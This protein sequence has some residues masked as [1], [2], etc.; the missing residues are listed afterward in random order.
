MNRARLGL[1]AV[2]LV[3]CTRDIYYLPGDYGF[4]DCPDYAE[5]VSGPPSPEEMEPLLQFGSRWEG[6]FSLAVDGST[7]LF[8][9]P[10][11]VLYDF[12]AAQ[13]A[14]RITPEDPACSGT[15]TAIGVPTTLT[16]LGWTSG[17]KIQHMFVAGEE[18]AGWNVGH[19]RRWEG[20]VWTGTGVSA[21]NEA[22]PAESDLYEALMAREAPAELEDASAHANFLR[23]GTAYVAF[24]VGEAHVP[25]RLSGTAHLEPIPE[26]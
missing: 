19:H 25:R 9:V 10:A 2:S 20:S 7:D 15:V 18:K 1:L 3:G 23:D 22:G 14:E 17:P 21:Y 13:L 4:W 12:A 26:P 6:V 11:E 5:R 16:V 8:D 24:E